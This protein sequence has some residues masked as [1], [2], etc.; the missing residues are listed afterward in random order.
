MS[1][2][3]CLR[4]CLFN[5]RSSDQS[6]TFQSGRLN[7]RVSIRE[8]MLRSRERSDGISVPI[9]AITQSKTAVEE[10]IHVST[11]IFFSAF[12]LPIRTTDYVR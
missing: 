4:K 7:S 10:D 12:A 1:S 6:L 8:N 3:C 2:Q 11:L 5:R 9:V